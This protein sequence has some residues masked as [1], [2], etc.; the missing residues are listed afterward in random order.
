MRGDGTY[1]T[2]TNTNTVT[3]VGTSGNE[4]SGTVTLAA[5]GAASI[6]QNGNTITISATDN[7][8]TYTAGTGLTLT[9]T[10]FDVDLSELSATTGAINKL[11]DHLIF[12]DNG[13][14]KKILFANVSNLVFD[15]AA[16]YTTNT[17]TVTSVATGH[18][19]GGTITTS[20]TI[21]LDYPVYY[22]DTQAALPTSGVSANAIGFEY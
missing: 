16:G 4:V 7:N 18:G 13:V 19:L 14:Q 15:N 6:S 2:P 21:T 10:E 8:T 12:T 17:G 22:A 20:G 11:Q 9:G 1:Q 3:T 5:S